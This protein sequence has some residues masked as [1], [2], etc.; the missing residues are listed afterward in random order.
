MATRST[1]Y[2]QSL[3][4]ELAKMSDETEWVEFKCGNKD[5]DRIAKYISGLSNAAALE[6][7]PKAYIIWGIENDT[8]EIVGTN[9]KYRKMKK[10]NEELESWLARMINP[11]TAFKFYEVPMDNDTQV[12]L[13]EIPAAEREPTKYGAVGYIR[14]GS[15]LK[16]LVEYPEKEAELWRK[17]DSVPYELR[18]AAENL[19]EDEVIKSLDF[20]QYYDKLEL[21]VPRSRAKI[22]E[23]FISEKFVI[24]NDAGTWNITNLGA[25]MIGKNLKSF[26][27][28]LKRTVRV[29]SYRG[30]DRLNGIREREFVNGYALSHEDIVQY[31]MAIIPQEEV[32]E[33]AIRHSVVSFPEIA[34]R[35]LLANC[36]IHQALDQRGTNPM[37]E[38][39]GD[40]I[41]FS[42]AGA[43]LVAI[44][45][46]I[47]TVPVSR[48]ENMAGFMHKCGICE[49]RG[50]GYDK[51]VMAT[52]RNIMMAPR[53]ENQNN[54]FTKA[55]LFSRVPFEILS[56]NDRIRT[57]YM[58]ACLVYVNF[59]A[60]DNRAVRILFGLDDKESYKA[61]R[62]IKDTM[63]AGLIKPLDEETAP[64]YMKYVPFWA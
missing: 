39:F 16:P 60:L 24:R 50:S 59:A 41:E 20:S 51:I 13:L 54:Q 2:L 31:I 61:S 34:I 9:F 40:R 5:P 30:K 63:T 44:E 12:V 15:N 38:I 43:P 11:K 47:D 28:L 4:R 29:V 37:V 1:E 45:R 7:K 33:G 46:I 8:H 19:S 18:I 64:R 26:E 35:E 52:S 22:F 55:V 17:F 36:M 57:C 53:V 27:S 48:N 14:V 42:N 32:I 6:E 10:G 21:P 56:K 23:D 58:Q 49:E 62:I 25:L 3:T